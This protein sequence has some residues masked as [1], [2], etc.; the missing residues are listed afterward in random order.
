MQDWEVGKV[1]VEQ[2]KKGSCVDQ[3]IPYRVRVAPDFGQP[4]DKAEEKWEEKMQEVVMVVVWQ[5]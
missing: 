5:A 1:M 2:K 4:V 3:E